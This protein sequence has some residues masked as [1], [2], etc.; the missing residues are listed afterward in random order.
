MQNGGRL[1]I[2]IVTAMLL[3]SL[4]NDSHARYNPR[5][6]WRTVKSGRFTVYYPVGHEAFARRVLDLSPEVYRDITGYLGYKPDHLPVVLN[7][8][9]DIFNGY[10][11]P[12]PNRISLFETPVFTLRG[13]GSSTSDLVDLVYTHEYTHYV[14]ITTSFGLYRFATRVF[15]EGIGI[16][17]ALSPGWYLE[18]VATN[19][20]TMF[21]DGGR[22]RSPEF[23]GEIRSFTDSGKLWSLSAAGTIPYYRPPGGRFY[24]SGY[25]MVNY[26]NRI[27]GQDAFPRITRYQ[28]SRL[29]GTPGGAFRHVAK[30]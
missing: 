28:G 6:K 17:N 11:T 7:P 1:L 15:G 21:T 3:F 8:G 24:L 5:W 14:H 30:K 25:H 18:G 10:Y 20:E 2:A 9:T 16:L 27:H 19:T 13:F 22:G 12:F 23:K 4:A 29:F 26:L